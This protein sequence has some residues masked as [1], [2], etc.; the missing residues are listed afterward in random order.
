MVKKRKTLED[1]IERLQERIWRRGRGK[2]KNKAD[3]LA[4][5]RSYLKDNDAKANV[6][7]QES[8]FSNMQSKHKGISS[9]VTTKKERAKAF[10]KAGQKPSAAE[11]DTIGYQK[12][13]G[14]QVYARRTK[15]R[16][17]NREVIVFRDKKGRFVHVPKTSR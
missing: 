12:R 13:G 4:V 15:Y 14:R 2:I 16:Y 11:F 3:F 8:V 17:K 6:A 7:L 1:D 10:V 9:A 5:Y